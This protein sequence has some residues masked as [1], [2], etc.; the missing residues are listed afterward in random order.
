MKKNILFMAAVLV[1]AACSK[2]FKES[3]ITNDGSI[4]AS[5]LVFNITVDSP[6]KAMKTAWENGD[7]VY[8]FFEDNTT[9][10]VK[11]TFDG[12]DW[13][14]TD[15][16]GGTSFSGLSLTAS[17]KKLTAVYFPDFVC[18]APPTY[19]TDRWSFGVV[20]GYYQ[21]TC[22]DYTVT[23]TGDV[24]TLYATLSLVA[25][26]SGLIVQLFVPSSEA[27][28]PGT[29]NEYALTAEQ[30]APFTFG[31]V[32]PGSDVE[33]SRGTYGHP[34]PGYGGTIGGD[35]GYYFWGM[36]NKG[37]M[38]FIQLVERNSTY[39]YAI[40]SKSKTI[41]KTM[42]SSFAA[43]ITGLTDKGTFVNMGYSGSPYWATGNLDKTNGKIVDPQ[44]YGERFEYGA[45]NV[46][47]NSNNHYTGTENPLPEDYDVAHSVNTDWRIPTMD[48]CKKLISNSTRIRPGLGGGL[49]VTS[50]TNGVA[51][52]LPAAGYSWATYYS[53]ST[54][55]SGYYWTSTP[56]GSNEAYAM[57]FLSAEDLSTG[58]ESSYGR[59]RGCSVRPVLQ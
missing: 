3:P 12:E 13:T 5:K 21:S 47:N 53:Q 39:K 38:K 28:A 8:V 59:D 52:F 45:T 29:G 20:S 42:L 26:N 23:T 35:S 56:N 22:V 58:S 34:L 7:D 15:N 6:T 27:S 48:Q 57:D 10:Y 19:D 40:S 41:N 9:Q 55:K 44:Q 50:K 30:I 16:A 25:P 51:L 11:M 43:K 33:Y 4:D 2:D 37:T 32:V 14:Y 17:G 24:N 36:L 31:G 18:S 54:G 49:L 46:F 1:F